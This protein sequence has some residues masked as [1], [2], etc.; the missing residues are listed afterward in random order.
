MSRPSQLFGLLNLLSLVIF[1]I[2]NVI[3]NTS[4]IAITIHTP[5]QYRSDPL[6]ETHVKW[7]QL[8]IRKCQAQAFWNK[9]LHMIDDSLNKKKIWSDVQAKVAY[10]P[11]NFLRLDFY[12]KLY[13]SETGS[14]SFIMWNYLIYQ[15]MLISM[16]E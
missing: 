1:I 10:M 2:I 7:R 4:T 16:P 15:V 8:F 14:L 5:W 13:V 12:Q 6:W 11:E 3:I 9:I